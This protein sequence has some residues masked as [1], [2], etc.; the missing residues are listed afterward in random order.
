[1]TKAVFLDRDGVIN[2]YP[3]DFL[4]VT[5]WERFKFLPG[6]FA[7]LKKLRE[8][9]Y[10][11]FVISNQAGVSKGVYPQR[12]LDR[13]TENMLAVLL[14]HKIIVSG[15]YYCVH[16]EEDKCQCR[17]PMTGLV[18]KAVEEFR[19]T[20]DDI[21]LAES[22]FIGDTIRDIKTGRSA[23]LR[24]ILVFSGKEKDANR[25]SWETP[26]DLTA[27]DLS[28]AARIITRERFPRGRNVPSDS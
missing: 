18:K 10:A 14:K 28:E 23:G 20:G 17:K 3:G 26:P 25:G 13:I 16:K 12:E 24:T 7:G 19:K 22:F 2:R 21:E 8:K 27:K 9:G 1:M 6:V 4:Y 15:V 5:S 11:L